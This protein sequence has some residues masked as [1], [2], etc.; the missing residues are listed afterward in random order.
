MDDAE[1]GLDNYFG[2]RK[3]NSKTYADL[4]VLEIKAKD[5]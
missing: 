2:I 4:I 1:P 5:N 3:L